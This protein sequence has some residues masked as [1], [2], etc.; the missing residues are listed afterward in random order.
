MKFHIDSVILWPKNINNELQIIEFE[1][2]KVNIIHGLSRTGKS[3]ILH[4]IDYAMGSSKCKIPIG[5]IR[6]SVQWF[7]LKISLRG[8]TW[9]LARRGPRDSSP[10]NDYYFE[11]FTGVIPE[12]LPVKTTRAIVK[13]KLNALTRVSD[14]PHSDEEVPS[15]LDARSSFRDMAAF[16]FLPQHIVANPNTL[17]FKADTWQHKEK[18]TRA[19]PY[20]LGIVDAEYVINERRKEAAQKEI[21]GLRKELS[22]I[23][24]SKNNWRFEVGRSLDKCIECG[25]LATTPETLELQVAALR[26]VVTACHERRLEGMLIEPKRLHTN[27]RFEMAVAKENEQQRL[28]DELAAEIAGFN[29][30]ADNSKQ[31]VETI[32]DDKKHVIGLGWLKNSLQSNGQCVACGSDGQLLT[33]VITNLESKVNKVTQIAEILEQ[34]P[35]I[36]NKIAGLKRQLS[37]AQKHLHDLRSEKNSILAEDDKLR[38]AIGDIYYLAGGIAEVLKK[39][40]QTS[41][42]KSITERIGVLEGEIDGYD[43]AMN[44]SSRQAKER[45]VDGALSEL[46]GD[47]AD[48]FGNLEAPANCVLKLDRKDLTIRF[49]KDYEQHDYLWEVGSGANWMGYHIAAFLGIHEFLLQEENLDLPPLSFLVIDQPSQVYFPSSEL[50][51]NA[52]DEDITTLRKTRTEDLIATRR[53]FEVLSEAIRRTKSNLQII[54]LEHA[55]KDIWGGVD[56]TRSAAS[57][58]VKGDGLIPATWI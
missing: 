32:K 31:F 37:K 45:I 57:W 43:K 52:L 29:S 18:L 9:I 35:V 13:A 20:A 39:I 38:N 34:N 1:E 4:I 42:D 44:K 26:T 3:S 2:G 40:G 28:V 7:G 47:Y 5:K 48:E 14:L 12:I 33:P 19:M 11:P 56:N 55:G 23:E 24:K 58:S 6:D 25:L 51:S 54:V 49:D 46:I 16:N 30:L 27:E 17:F 41:A 15:K 10:S 21:D 50:G 36:D 22:V 53:I 8:E